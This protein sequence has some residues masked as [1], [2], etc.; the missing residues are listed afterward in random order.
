MKLNLSGWFAK[1]ATGG[2]LHP[3]NAYNLTVVIPTTSSQHYK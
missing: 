1:I 2:I 3:P